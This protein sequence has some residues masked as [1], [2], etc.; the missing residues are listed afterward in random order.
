MPVCPGIETARFAC[1]VF[2]SQRAVS[3][4]AILE[5]ARERGLARALGVLVVSGPT[6]NGE[7]LVPPPREPY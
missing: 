1:F 7:V 5:Q 2:G 3:L 4:V 6:M